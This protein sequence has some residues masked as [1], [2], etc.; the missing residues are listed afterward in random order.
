VPD[1]WT[2]GGSGTN[3]SSST[4]TSDAHSG[5]EAETVS[6]SSFTSGDRRLQVTQDLGQCAPPVIPGDK[7]TTTAFLKGSGTLK[8]VAY[9]RTEQGVWQYWTQSPNLS[10]SSSYAQ[11]SWTT[12]AVP[13]A[14]T[15]LSVGISLRSTGSFTAD[16][17]TLA[18]VSS[19]DHTPPTVSITTPAAGAAVAGTVP[20]TAT[21][22]DDVAV[23]SVRFFLD[24]VSL[25]S[26]AAPTPA[27]SSTYKWNWNT[28]AVAAGSHVLTTVATDSSGNQTTSAPVTVTLGNAPP[29]V[30]IT[31]PADGTAVTGTVPITATATDDGTIASVRFF[32]DGVSLGSKTAPTPAG[33][34]TYQWNWN[35]TGLADGAHVLT[36]VATDNSGN[37]TTSA[38]VTVTHTTGDTQKPAVTITSPSGGAAV[39]GTVPILATATDNVGVVSVRFFLDGVSLG[40]KTA[41]TQTGGSIYKWN[42]TTGSTSSGVHTLTAVATDAAGN[43]TTSDPV[44]VTVG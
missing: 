24:G 31:G 16:D 33:S 21:A 1:C 18:D 23:A 12:P 3:T 32:L 44:T 39:V 43:Q 13:A 37:T 34:S 9:Y 30:S 4:T 8:W 6:I 17:F 20:I 10:V 14:A 35:T 22:T 38:A 19:G 26:K 28:T 29:V 2:V 41:P 7:Y 27:G 5:S 42:W 15:A 11:Q 25:G 36:A 40:S